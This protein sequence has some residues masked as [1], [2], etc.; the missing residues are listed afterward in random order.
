MASGTNKEVVRVLLIGTDVPRNITLPRSSPRLACPG[1]YTA[2]H[3]GRGTEQ[4]G[5]CE[6]FN[7]EH[8]S[9]LLDKLHRLNQQS[10]VEMKV[11]DESAVKDNTDMTRDWLEVVTAVETILASSHPPSLVPAINSFLK[12]VLKY[13]TGVIKAENLMRDTHF[14]LLEKLLHTNR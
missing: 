13:L 5:L 14:H 12:E 3:S 1:V 11:V 2:G 8:L 6:E 4:G 9:I 10:D 7:K